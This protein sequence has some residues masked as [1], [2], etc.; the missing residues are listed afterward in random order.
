MQRLLITFLSVFSIVLFADDTNKL[1]D[2]INKAVENGEKYVKLDGWYN[3]GKPL[4]LT[5]KHS[6]LTI[7]GQG[8]TVFCGGKKITNWQANALKSLPGE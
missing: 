7:D 4:V 1:Q 2:I 5:S 8:K 3:L 6:G